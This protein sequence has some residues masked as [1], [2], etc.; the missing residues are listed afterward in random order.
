M[1]KN[2]NPQWNE[3][4]TLNLHN[5][6][7]TVRVK[8]YDSNW[9]SKDD[10]MGQTDI[11]PRYD[12]TSQSMHFPLILGQDRDRSSDAFSQ[13]FKGLSLAWPREMSAGSKK[14]GEHGSAARRHQR[15]FVGTEA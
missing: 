7:N 12:I 6:E 15:C 10:F 1:E 8:V 11:T 9:G 2:L 4:F 5:I 3:R 13:A 14:V